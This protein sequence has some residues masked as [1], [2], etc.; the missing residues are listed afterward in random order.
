MV[1]L[2]VLKGLPA[3]GKSTRA[4]ELVDQKGWVRVNRDLL[5]EMLHYN[6]WSGKNESH[7][8]E[9]EKQLV[10]HFLRSGMNVVVDD[11]NLN[12]QNLAMWMSVSLFNN[13]KF[14]QE[15]IQTTWQECIERDKGREKSVG[16]HVIKQMALQYGQLFREDISKEIIVCDIDGTIANIDHRLHWV[17]GETKDWKS[18]FAEM[19]KD[20]VRED[21]KAMLKEY[22]H[23]GHDI[24]FVSARPEDYRE[25]TE[26]WLM[27]NLGYNFVLM[28]GK[29]DKRP[30]TM[31]KADIYRKYLQH[32]PIK[33]VIDDR[34]SVIRMWQEEFGLNVIDVGKGIEF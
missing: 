22:E 12:E 30:D 1:K 2:H 27:D 16:A 10:G 17:Q 33:A 4:K 13:A 29:G 6:A 7:T 5:R 14:S 28:R 11:C 24:L 34:P 23:A 20:T 19:D 18:F 26:K 9:A 31:V 25:Q 8:V 3:S 21:V 32:Y 15:H